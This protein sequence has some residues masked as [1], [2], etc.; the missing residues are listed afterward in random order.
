MTWRLKFS[1][2]ELQFLPT[3]LRPARVSLHAQAVE[4]QLVALLAAPWTIGKS[5]SSMGKIIHKGH[6]AHRY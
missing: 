2:C 5:L 6:R 4:A 3:P 1:Q